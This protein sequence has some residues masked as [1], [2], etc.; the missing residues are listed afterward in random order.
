MIK[1]VKWISEEEG[2][3][4]YVKHSQDHQ[5]PGKCKVKPQTKISSLLESHSTG[6]LCYKLEFVG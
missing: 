3:G 1:E 5:P 2:N 4:V 6:M